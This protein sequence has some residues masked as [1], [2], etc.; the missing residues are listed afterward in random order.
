M[1][2]VTPRTLM[3]GQRLIDVPGECVE[4]RVE[5]GE[6]IPVE[7]L[8]LEQSRALRDRTAASVGRL[9]ARARERLREAGVDPGGI[10]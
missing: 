5:V 8:A 3:K 6:P 4:W 1:I 10:D 2:R 9:R 7:G